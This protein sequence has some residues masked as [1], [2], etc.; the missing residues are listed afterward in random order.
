[1]RSASSQ[2]S[3][4]PRP[5]RSRSIALAVV[6]AVHLLLIAGLIGLA[7][8]PPETK[9]AP[10]AIQLLPV[11]E[12]VAPTADVEAEQTDDIV[13]ALA[14]PPRVLPAPPR[15]PLPT[16]EALAILD[17]DFDLAKVPQSTAAPKAAAEVADGSATGKDSSPVYGP[18]L[19]PRT[20][21]GGE[22]LYKAEWQVEPTN[23]QLAFYL[24]DGGA[25]DGSYGMIA[26][27]T[28]AGYRVE[29][30][31]ELEDSPSGS[32]LAGALR[33]AAWQFRVRPPRIGGRVLVGAWVRIRVDFT[34]TGVKSAGGP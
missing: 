7:R 15:P 8:T 18:V 29:D 26:C 20:G 22:T 21:P 23:A 27:R 30:C 9:S 34:R 24:P 6:I 3:S 25:P 16:P 32:R 4:D 14:E 12:A 28:V 5:Y 17:L 10:Q 11:D 2:V 13:P 31:V 33:Q 1:M 19:G